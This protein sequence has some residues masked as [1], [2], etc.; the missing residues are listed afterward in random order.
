MKT[1]PRF[2]P[3]ILMLAAL[4]ISSGCATH[5]PMSEVKMYQEKRFSDGDTVRTRYAHV[6]ATFSKSD[7]GEMRNLETRD[8]SVLIEAKTAPVLGMASIFMR[9][10]TANYAISLSYGLF[11]IGFDMTF[12]VLPKHVSNTYLTFGFTNLPIYYQFILQRRLLD[13]NPFG[14][15]LGFQLRQLEIL[16]EP[17][18][19]CYLCMI[20][21]R[22][23]YLAFGP[24]VNFAI[25]DNPN[26]LTRRRAM[27]YGNIS[28]NYAPAIDLYFPNFGV[29]LIIH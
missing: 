20:P 11:Y 22:D 4:A 25:S 6:V 9:P 24:R 29:A 13:G 21:E 1:I 19:G 3:A 26:I 14:L 27:L 10:E 23:Q 7:I 18:E 28:I 5:S 2:F 8:G 15:S 16:H 17:F 12:E